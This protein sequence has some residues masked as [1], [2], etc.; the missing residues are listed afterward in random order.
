[1]KR[2][3]TLHPFGCR[4]LFAF[5]GAPFGSSEALNA[6]GDHTIVNWHRSR[7]RG[8]I[9][10]FDDVPGHRVCTAPS[11]HPLGEVPS[12]TLS[13]GGRNAEA[14]KIFMICLAD[15][16]VPNGVTKTTQPSHALSARTA[17]RAGQG[18]DDTQ[19]T[20][21][22][23]AAGPADPELSTTVIHNTSL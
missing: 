12:G 15:R 19:Y 23:L 13:G 1:M 22:A 3:S 6:R 8:R 5:Q 14:F 17:G 10:S 9:R 21:H 11:L 2:R 4:V 7:L 16:A 18:S 20:V